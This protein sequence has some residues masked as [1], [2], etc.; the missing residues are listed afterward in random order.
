[1]G[2]FRHSGANSCAPY[3]IE[4]LASASRPASAI[5]TRET[6]TVRPPASMGSASAVASQARFLRDDHITTA[7]EL[8]IKSSYA[9]CICLLF[10]RVVCL[11]AAIQ[12]DL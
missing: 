1:M 9:A 8:I 12:S 4:H 11:V 7:P 6:S 3:Q 2:Q 10:Y 5:R